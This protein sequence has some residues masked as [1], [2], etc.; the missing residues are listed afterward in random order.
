MMPIISEKGSH[1]D[2]SISF[3]LDDDNVQPLIESILSR[4]LESLDTDLKEQ[5]K[6]KKEAEIRRA[7]VMERAKELQQ[8]ADAYENKCSGLD[9][10]KKKAQEEKKK[11]EENFKIA[12]SLYNDEEKK[13]NQAKSFFDNLEKLSSENEIAY[14]SKLR[15]ACV[16][17]E[18]SK[19]F[20]KEIQASEKKIAQIC[21]AKTNIQKELI[22]FTNEGV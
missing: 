15:E 13:L 21:E 12:V 9:Q 5:K 17:E 18:K 16:A 1:D 6:K 8:E 11:A 3:W 7:E 2:I 22:S 20:E 19:E 10:E 14:E 4:R